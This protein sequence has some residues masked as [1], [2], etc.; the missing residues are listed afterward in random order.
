[1]TP[2]ARLRRYELNHL[3]ARAGWPQ[4]GAADAPTSPALTAAVLGISVTT[5]RRL[6]A[7]PWQ[8]TGRHLWRILRA[9]NRLGVPWTPDDWFGLTGE[10][11]AVTLGDPNPNSPYEGEPPQ[12]SRETLA[13]LALPLPLGVSGPPAPVEPSPEIEDENNFS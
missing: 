1:M 12:P 6:E 2:L 7:D 3:L 10:G 5:L 11:A 13:E 8:V 4:S 9:V